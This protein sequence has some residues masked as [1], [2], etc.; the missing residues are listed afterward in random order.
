MPPDRLSASY[1]ML[2]QSPPL[3]RSPDFPL[4]LPTTL[5]FS[6]RPPWLL[7]PPAL[8][9]AP[10]RPEPLYVNLALGPRGPSPASSAPPPLPAHPHDRSDLAPSPPPPQKQ[11]APWGHHTPHRVPGPWG[12]PDPL[13]YRA[14]P[15][16][17]RR[18]S[19]EGPVQ[20]WGQGEGAVPHPPTL[21]PAG[22]SFTLRARPKT[23]AEPELGG[24][25]LLSLPLSLILGPT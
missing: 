14:A 3:H 11:R 10:H 17:Y 23:T 1:G 7:S 9:P 18:A 2:G 24:T 16:A 25:F 12:P 8:G 4:Q 21:L 6:P 15:P 13:P 5:L 20:E 19:T 22:P